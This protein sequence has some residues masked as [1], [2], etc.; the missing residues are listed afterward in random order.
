MSTITGYAA[1]NCAEQFGVTLNKYADPTEDARIGLT[2]DEA[3]EVASED[4]ALI[5]CSLPSQACI[6]LDEADY[7]LEIF[8]AYDMAP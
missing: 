5:Y 8:V 1:I 6:Y 3:R 2:V 4:P 7:M